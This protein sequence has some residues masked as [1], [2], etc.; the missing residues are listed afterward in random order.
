[1]LSAAIIEI[2]DA[3][4]LILIATLVIWA[5]TKFHPYEVCGNLGESLFFFDR[6]SSL[7]VLLTLIIYFFIV[8][9]AQ[10]NRPK[11]YSHLRLLSAII[12]LIILAFIAHPM[13]SFYLFFE[14]SL[15]PIFLLIMG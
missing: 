15:I 10:A 9:G 1:M 7:L 3:T 11:I 8:I 5:V 14:F 4:I 6:M 2:R 12:T 13:L